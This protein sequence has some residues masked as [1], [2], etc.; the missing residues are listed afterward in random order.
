MRV[1]ALIRID[2]EDDVVVLISLSK[3][4]TLPYKITYTA[5]QFEIESSSFVLQ[6]GYDPV[7]CI[8]PTEK[9]L[10]AAEKSWDIIGDFVSD[11]P[12]CF[13]AKIRSR[14]I[15]AKT[16]ETGVQ[17]RQITRLL[18]RYWA[19]GMSKHALYP[20]NSNKG[21]PGKSR[22]YA[23]QS[24]RKVR[25]EDDNQRMTIGD[26]ELALIQK[27][28]NKYYNKH[29]KYQY[30]YVYQ[31]MILD[32]YTDPL[33][34]ALAPSYPTENQFRYHASKYVDVKKRFGSTAYR[35]D[36]RGITGSSRSEALGPGDVYQ[37]DATIADVYLVS[38][39][40]RT[41]VVG[42]PELYF[43]TDVFSRMIVG[44]YTCL[45]S[46]SWENARMALI[47]TF[48]PK[49]ALCAQYDVNI[50]EDMWPCSGLPRELVVDNGE[51]IS[52]ASMGRSG[53]I[54]RKIMTAIREGYVG[55]NPLGLHWEKGLGE[56]HTCVNQ[57]DS[58]FLS[59]SG[60]N[61]NASGFS[62]IGDSGMGKTSTV[63]HALAMF[64]QM[65]IHEQYN[66]YPFPNVQFV[67]MRLEC[68]H[69]A[70]V[71]GLCGEFFTE[72]D[73]LTKDN[74][75]EKF[76][77]GGRATTDQMIPQMALI[78]QRHG[79]GLLVIDE[80]QNLSAAKSGGAD[81]MLNFLVQLVNKIGLPVLLIGTPMAKGY[82]SQDL[83]A[84]RRSTG[85]QGMEEFSPFE[86]DERSWDMLV[87][88]L[89]K[90]QW[91][92]EKSVLT[93][94]MSDALYSFSHGNVDV[95]VKLY[96]EAQRIAISDRTEQVTVDAIM[97]AGHSKSFSMVLKCLE[98]QEKA[99]VK[100]QQTKRAKKVAL[101]VERDAALQDAISLPQ[102]Q[103]SVNSPK[104]KKSEQVV[105]VTDEF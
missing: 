86:R 42:R 66:E 77:K 9:Q 71:K 14:F 23:Q 64:P 35:K 82:L 98:E 56:L 105:S 102:K 1:L 83:M 29:T 34:G 39:G 2:T 90:Y 88:G 25:F 70:S 61:A 30:R 13:D 5:F 60:T 68:P 20:Q 92:A 75:Y 80:I 87:K 8:N 46:A 41:A 89:W 81:K 4:D 76:A 104:R 51:L 19:G 95:T 3:K 11:E 16:K 79:L 44:F 101:P 32:C 67:W 72:F 58:G 91:T 28:M 59:V 27:Y 15:A 48:L 36:M 52:K 24:G 10:E 50:T 26:A 93:E 103:A 57:K 54:A 99:K 12:D 94:E 65:I 73:R 85:Q 18:Y 45:E 63:N 22:T 6:Q 47:N 38:H 62:I 31:K 53:E 37:I 33:T 49:Q 43:V 78:A 97:K 84:A 40:D 100:V 7:V 74:T 55:R 21:G 69:D 17:R 96:M